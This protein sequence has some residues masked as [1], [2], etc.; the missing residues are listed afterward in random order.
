VVVLASAEGRREV[1]L[2]EYF[3]GYRQSVREPGELIQSV[4]IPLPLAEI[5]AFH[6]IAKRRFD[7]ISSVAVGYAIDVV[8]GEVVKARIGLG[9]VA[10]TPIRALDTE[11][12][13]EGRPWSRETVRVAAGVLRQEGTPIDDQR[14]SADYRAAMLGTSLLKLHAQQARRRHEAE[15][16]GLRDGGGR[17]GSAS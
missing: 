2:S 7:D 9:G 1:P 3:T 11:A 14:A 17:E 10:A 4:R 15:P 6:K 8:D 12:A 16:P 5:T 13:L